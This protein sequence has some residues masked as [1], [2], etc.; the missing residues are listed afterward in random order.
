MGSAT[1]QAIAA[2]REALAQATGDA[3]VLG[4]ELIAARDTIAGA[5]Q[6]KAVLADAAAAP[7][8]KS[9]LVD[10][11]FAGFGAPTRDVLQRVAE[12]R[13]SKADDL[14]AGLEELGIRA[15]AAS[16]ADGDVAIQELAAFQ[17]AVSADA[18]L[19]YAVGSALVPGTEKAAVVERL[20][21]D[22]ATPQTI[23]ILAALVSRSNGRR[24]GGMIKRATSLVADQSGRAVAEVHTATALDA[25][26][27]ERL[28][29]TIAAA[30]QRDVVLTQ[31][32]DP[33]LIGGVR[34]VI[35]DRVID[36]S[37]ATRLTDL[38]LA[39]VG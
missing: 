14:L 38:R 17:K 15:M 28:R 25:A 29:A 18:D 31:I 11:A 16:L 6:L 19:E 10:K 36:G 8:T 7:A 33:A 1:T 23:A 32:V 22:K 12:A 2:G 13:W 9:A 37:V 24:I 39:L 26:Q 35:G 3:F 4:R 27:A 21:T 34:V 30:E 20:L 5:A